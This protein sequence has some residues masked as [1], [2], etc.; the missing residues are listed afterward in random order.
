MTTDL[1]KYP[2]VYIEQ[3]LEAHKT[4]A[5]MDAQAHYLKNVLRRQDGDRVRLFNG[6]DGEWL[7]ALCASGRKDM[8][9]MPEVQLRPQE[10]R[11]RRVHLLFT[12]LKK[13]RM[14]VLIEKAV[15][16]DATDL[17]PVL[18]A[19]AEVRELKIERVQAQMIE[20]AEQCERLDIPTLHPVMTLERA[21]SSLEGCP[22][23][24]G[25]ERSDARTLEDGMVPLGDCA[26][27]VGPAG[28]WTEAER[29]GLSN[30]PAVTPV[31]LG[32]NILRAETAALVL[33]ARLAL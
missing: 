31:S 33:L 29:T 30:S 23:F 22:V 5:L 4:I 1:H 3:P 21:L 11:R 2:R 14:D 26:A 16:L 9:A 32:A 15:E 25:I 20:A 18:T 17:H 8:Q 28:G 10:V 12:P 24:A 27:L 6:R 13:D 7:A 19:R